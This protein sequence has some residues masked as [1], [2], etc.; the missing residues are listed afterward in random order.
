MKI[1]DP[2]KFSQIMM[3][4]C[5]IIGFIA[6]AV[7]IVAVSMKEYIIA[8]AMLLVAVIQIMNFLK[9]RKAIR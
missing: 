7:G 1:K 3:I 2:R 4:I 6:L 8:V 9:W 5:I